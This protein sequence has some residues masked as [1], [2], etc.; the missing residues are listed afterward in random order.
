MDRYRVGSG[1][2][3]AVIVAV[4]LDF[5][6]IERFSAALERHGDRLRRRLFTEGEWQACETRPDRVQ[7]LAARFAAKEAAL[8]A[9]GTGWSAG[10]S[11]NQIELIGGRGKP[12][13]LLFH[14]AA[15]RRAD[16]LGVTGIHVSITHQPGAAAAVVILER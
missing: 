16:R 8:K 2:G 15:R 4:G 13:A 3:N 6:E 12:P 1:R 5:V 9:L 14:G 7:A 10:L 11:F